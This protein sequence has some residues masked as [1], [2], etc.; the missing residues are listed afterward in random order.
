MSKVIRLAIFALV[1]MVPALWAPPL[2]MERRAQGAACRI[3]GTSKGKTLS[4][5]PVASRFVAKGHES[6][7][8]GEALPMRGGLAPPRV[9]CASRKRSAVARV[10]WSPAP[11][12]LPPK[13][14]RA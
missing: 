7:Q 8:G 10:S 4:A 1:M 2:R 3:I 13:L 14:L 11:L 9:A 5:F 6:P 12:W